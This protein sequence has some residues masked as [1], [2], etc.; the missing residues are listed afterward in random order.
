[1]EKTIT[2]K[3]K[4]TVEIEVDLAPEE[5]QRFLDR[6][7]ARLAAT[8][9]LP[10]FRKGK[11][12]Q[13]IL[14]EKVGLKTILDEAAGEAVQQT[15]AEIVR[16]EQLTTVGPPEISILKQAEGN[17]F[18]FRATAVLLPKVTLAD[19]AKI[20]ARRQ[21]VAVTDPDVAKALDDLRD[22]RRTEVASLEPA[23][24]GDKIEIDL[25]VFRDGVPLAAAQSRNHPIILGE[26]HLIPGFEEQLIGLRPGDQRQFTLTFPPNYHQRNLA[27]QS[28]Q[29]RV[30]VTNL[31]HLQRPTADDAFAQRVGSFKTLVE[32]KA[33]L[34]LSLEQERRDREE[35]RLEGEL[36]DRLIAVSRF[37]ELPDR[38]IDQET[39]KMLD[40]LAHDVEHRGLKMED[41]LQSLKQTRA[42]LKLEFAPAGVRRI[43]AALIIRAL[44]EREGISV[45]NEEVERERSRL[46]EEYAEEPAARSRLDEEE[47]SRYLATVL[48]NRKV[49]RRLKELAGV[50]ETNL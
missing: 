9:S 26:G 31:F 25:E 19:P 3:P 28:A 36:L 24:R 27:G 48:T 4:S 44:A 7:Q 45:T 49:I 18:R 15:Y 17:P 34:R 33:K 29:F 30:R 47:V 2:R 10:G 20:S 12:P 43:K 46:R 22:L 42:S 11:V 6:A 16:Q 41:Y 35:Q 40:E 23:R 38:L 21:P 32:L 37:E 39:G 1:M 5:F 14:R 13:P 8:V 50:T